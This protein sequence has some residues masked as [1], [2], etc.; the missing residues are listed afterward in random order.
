MVLKELNLIE[1]HY[2]Y[3]GHITVNSLCAINYANKRRMKMKRLAC[4]NFFTFFFVLLGLEIRAYT[5]SHFTS[6]F[7]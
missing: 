1:A 6:P 2:M 3:D 5:L 4:T 7:L